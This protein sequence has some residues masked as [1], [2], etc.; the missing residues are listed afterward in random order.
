[1]I[2]CNFYESCRLFVRLKSD[3]FNIL[4]INSLFD[5]F[6]DQIRLVAF[7]SLHPFLIFRHFDRK[8]TEPSTQR[9]GIAHTTLMAMLARHKINFK[10]RL[11]L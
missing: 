1:M 2:D 8:T 10:S 7:R 11:K 6:F 5:N 4:N 9:C 3:L